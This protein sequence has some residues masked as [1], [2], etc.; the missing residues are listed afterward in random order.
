MPKYGL[1][2]GSSEIPAQTVDGDYM[3]QDGAYVKIFIA[4]DSHTADAQVAAFHLDKGQTVR[5]IK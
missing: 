2:S 3:L 5:E 1:F 4:K